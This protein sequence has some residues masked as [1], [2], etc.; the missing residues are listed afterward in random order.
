VIVVIFPDNYDLQLDYLILPDLISRLFP[1]S[2]SYLVYMRYDMRMRVGP[3]N[4]GQV[5]NAYDRSNLVSNQFW[6]ENTAVQIYFK[7]NFIFGLGSYFWRK[8]IKSQET[9]L[10]SAGEDRGVALLRRQRV[11]LGINACVREVRIGLGLREWIRVD[12]IT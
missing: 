10:G 2:Y 6:S 9:V 11:R 1:E 12:Y 5:P 7:N 4:V 8:E 3:K